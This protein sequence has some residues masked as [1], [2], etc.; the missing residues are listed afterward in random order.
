MILRHFMR[1]RNELIRL[2]GPTLKVPLSFKVK[3]AKNLKYIST[4]FAIFKSVKNYWKNY[5]IFK[6]VIFYTLKYM[7][8]NIPC[9]SKSG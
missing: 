4:K 2:T 9:R 3:I 1:K 8:K 7:Y 5:A 6:S